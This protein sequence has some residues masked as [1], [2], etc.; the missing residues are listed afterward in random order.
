MQVNKIKKHFKLSCVITE[1]EKDAP[2][3]LSHLHSCL[4]G[5]IK[6]SYQK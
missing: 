1:M 5:P 3:N 2:D 4:T 6:T